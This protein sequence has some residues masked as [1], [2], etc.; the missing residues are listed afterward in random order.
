MPR[1]EPA[2]SPLLARALPD[3]LDL[4]TKH[5]LALALGGRE[6]EIAKFCSLAGRLLGPRK[7]ESVN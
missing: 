5:A 1:T 7:Q 4:V 6:A 3:E 2:T